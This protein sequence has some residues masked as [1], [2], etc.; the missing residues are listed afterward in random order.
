MSSSSTEH[1]STPKLMITTH[2][3]WNVPRNS[4]KGHP[5]FTLPYNVRIMYA[6]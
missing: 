2:G 3:K 5:M 6:T 4:S 1:N